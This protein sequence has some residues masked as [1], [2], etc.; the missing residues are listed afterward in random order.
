[1]PTPALSRLGT[2]MADDATR[3]YFA[4]SDRDRA[5]FEAGIKLGSIAHQYV[6]TPL[7]SA[8]APSL[9]RAIE[10]AT[11]VQPLVERIR[12]RID[13]KRMRVRG[14][15][16]YGVLTEDLLDVEV[17]VRVGSARAVGTLRYVPEL[18]YPLMYLKAIGGPTKD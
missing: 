10:A 16:R 18:D 11:K 9:E 6:G 14:P 8:S 17:A 12:V 3:E 1:M 5:A 4:G 2:V 13:R 15:Y 7:T